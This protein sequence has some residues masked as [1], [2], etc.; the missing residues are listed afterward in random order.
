MGESLQ[1][2]RLAAEVSDTLHWPGQRRAAQANTNMLS[3]LLHYA[4]AALNPPP[5][6][7]LL[8][9]Q[10]PILPPFSG[11]QNAAGERL[12]HFYVSFHCRSGPFALSDRGERRRRPSLFYWHAANISGGT[13]ATQH[14]LRE[15]AC[16]QGGWLAIRH[17]DLDCV[18][19]N[20]SLG[21]E[22]WADGGR[23]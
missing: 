9:F 12:F 7:L 3:H 1:T 21:S 20:E 10:S 22:P 16:R 18:A 5:L 4:W 6:T 19:H 8:P 13:K 11:I 15:Q 17:R 23:R 14:L 2:V